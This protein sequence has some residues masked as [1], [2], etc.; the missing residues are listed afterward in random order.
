[1]VVLLPD[2]GKTLD[3]CLPQLTYENW[4]T[5]NEQMRGRSLAVKF[6]KFELKYDKDLVDDMQAMG[7]KDAFHADDADF[8]KMSAADLFIGIFKQFTY[9]KIDE[10]GTEAAAVTVTGMVETSV[11]PSTEIDFYMNRPFAFMIKE[12]ST[13]S[14]LFMGKITTL[15]SY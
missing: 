4:K 11:G 15:K 14:I 9:L 6:P 2:A 13:G 10:E 3:E 8:T 7:M 1:M 12:K 5:W